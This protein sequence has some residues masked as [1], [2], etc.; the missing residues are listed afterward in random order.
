MDILVEMASQTRPVT[1]TLR[2]FIAV[3]E[4]PAWLEE[5]RQANR[6]YEFMGTEAD[7]VD[8]WSEARKKRYW[9]EIIA[10]E[11]R[12]LDASAETSHPWND[13]ALDRI[14]VL[15]SELA[16]KNHEKAFLAEM[17]TVLRED[18]RVRSAESP[19]G[20]R[21]QHFSRLFKHR[22]VPHEHRQ[23]PEGRFLG[24]QEVS[25]LLGTCLREGDIRAVRDAAMF[26]LIYSAAAT[27]S[28]LASLD[29]A[30]WD[31]AT[32]SVRLARGYCRRGGFEDRTVEL[33]FET[34]DLLTCWVCLRGN[35]PGHLFYS[36]DRFGAVGNERITIAT[37]HAA[38][39]QR[40]NSAVLP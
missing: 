38:L 40:C 11:G 1:R 22:P 35:K 18:Q 39:K 16:A 33:G 19:L 12:R 27:T 30:D 5:A 28:E 2:E 31:S 29:L 34:A 26:V 23:V 15:I 32:A 3:G 37:V 17:A 4:V 8:C 20:R 6:Y 25:R 9:A 21:W 10:R 13:P 7:S 36:L 24:H 14:D